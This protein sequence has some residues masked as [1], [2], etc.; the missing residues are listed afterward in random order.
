MRLITLTSLSPTLNPREM[1]MTTRQ[2][3][4]IAIDDSCDV[5]SDRL[6]DLVHRLIPGSHTLDNTA[7]DAQVTD[8]EWDDA[9]DEPRLPMSAEQARQLTDDDGRI[10]LVTTIDQ[11]T[12]FAGV[13]GSTTQGADTA[14][15]YVHHQVFD[16]GLPYDCSLNII[17][18]SGSD[19]VV[20]YS[21][22]LTDA[23][24]EQEGR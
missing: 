16:F 5:P 6:A 4:T 24:T 15:D 7:L 10:T 1:P 23:L 12:Y 2:I 22:D 9:G 11:D 14:E 13:I 20:T 17:A 3:L 19:F 18:V 8:F 21:T